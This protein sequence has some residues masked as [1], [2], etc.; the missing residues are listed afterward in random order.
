[1]TIKP[2]VKFAATILA[3]SVCL[4]FSGAVLAQGA[5]KA[6]GFYIYGAIGQ[7]SVDLG[8][9]DIDASLVSVGVTGL[10]SSAD[11]TDV[12]YKIFGGYMFNKYLALEAGWVDLGKF[13]Y[14]ASFTGPVAG[15]AKAEIKASGFTIAAVGTLPVT[16]SFGLFVKAG[17]I[18]AKLSAS[19][20]ATGS[21]TTW[22]G[23]DSDT[24]W[25]GNFGIGATYSFNPNL[26]VRAEW[27]RFRKLGDKNTT[28]EGDVDL[29]S[30]GLRY[31]F[32]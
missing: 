5:P 29:L 18:D 7:S 15:A 31:T 6:Q 3:T 25:K 24:S 32:N 27:E 19:G 8:K 4:A 2:Q 11:E 9:G 30:V 22:S 21:G 23:S 16:D 17:T 28:G 10:S 12:G 26:A 1:M 20:V 13:A 14:T